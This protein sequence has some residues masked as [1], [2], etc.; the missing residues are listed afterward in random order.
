MKR[1]QERAL[2]SWKRLKMDRRRKENNSGKRSDRERASDIGRREQQRNAYAAGGELK[3]L[4]EERWGKISST[5]NSIRDLTPGFDHRLSPSSAGLM[6]EPKHSKADSLLNAGLPVIKAL[7]LIAQAASL[8]LLSC[9]SGSRR[10]L[11]LRERSYN[12]WFTEVMLCGKKTLFAFAS[13]DCERFCS[14]K[15]LFSFLKVFSYIC[16]SLFSSTALIKT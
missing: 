1:K 12:V 11:R 16:H 3:G 10:A 6:Q 4:A 5:D 14:R 2:L 9:V 15:T 7:S 13:F 8:S